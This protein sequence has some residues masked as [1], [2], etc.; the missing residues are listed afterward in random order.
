MREPELLYGLDDMLQET[1]C[2]VLAA[3]SP[4]ALRSHCLDWGLMLKEKNYYSKRHLKASP[5]QD[6]LPLSVSKLKHFNVL[7][8][9]PDNKRP[10]Y[11]LA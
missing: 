3:L 6:R 7:H 5:E 2:I 1:R 8:S 4:V 10:R 11:S 9:P